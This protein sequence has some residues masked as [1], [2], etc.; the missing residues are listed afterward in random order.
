MDGDG[1]FKI[2]KTLL[3]ASR[4]RFDSDNSTRM[5]KIVENEKVSLLSKLKEIAG[6]LKVR[7]SFIFNKAFDPK[8]KP[9]ADVVTAFFALLELNRQ[10]LVTMKQEKMFG[11]LKVLRRGK[12]A[13]ISY[14]IDAVFPPQQ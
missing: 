8:T 7:A 14:S 13:D 11:D 4:Q 3:D 2:Y 12:G 9:K 1:L 6:F 10:E 5:G